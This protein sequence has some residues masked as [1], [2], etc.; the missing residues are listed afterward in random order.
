LPPAAI[1]NPALV[2]ISDNTNWVSSMRATSPGHERAVVNVVQVLH[3]RYP[4]TLLVPVVGAYVGWMARIGPLLGTWWDRQVLKK[5][6]CPYRA[7]QLTATQA[8][9]GPQELPH[10]G[11]SSLPSSHQTANYVEPARSAQAT[12]LHPLLAP[13]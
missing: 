2:G 12:A 7:R 3:D 1:L 6:S 9:C 8:H 11:Q 5:T 13:P 10:I 4:R